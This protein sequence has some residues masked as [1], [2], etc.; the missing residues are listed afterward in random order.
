MATAPSLPAARRLTTAE[1]LATPTDGP[2]SELIYGEVVMAARPSDEHQDLV[3]A[4]GHVLRRWTEHEK[5]GKLSFEI[6]MVLDE[7]KRLV[8]SPDLLFLTKAH[9]ARRRDGRVYGPADLCVEILSPSDKPWVQRRKY[10][11]YERY[12]VRWYWIVQ[13]DPANPALEENE[14]VGGVFVPRTEVAGDMWFSPGLF[15]GLAF[16]LHPL[17]QGDA[18]AAVKGKTK[19]LM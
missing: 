14:L 5:L 7:E 6:D 17:L 15:P 8:Y 9:A 3:Y 19:K 1:Y 16:R 11:D 13:P 4:L 12:G 2:R 10:S 18:R